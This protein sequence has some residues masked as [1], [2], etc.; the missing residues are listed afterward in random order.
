M[1]KS[2]IPQRTRLP[3][4]EGESEGLVWKLSHWDLFGILVVGGKLTQPP[5]Q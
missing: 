4:G 3:R 5:I 1:T 2:F